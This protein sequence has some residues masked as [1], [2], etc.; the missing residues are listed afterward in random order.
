MQYFWQTM[1]EKDMDFIF[2]NMNHVSLLTRH[3]SIHHNILE[4]IP[5]IPIYYRS[6]PSFIH[7]LDISDNQDVLNEFTKL[8][9]ILLDDVMSCYVLTLIYSKPDS[10]SHIH[11]CYI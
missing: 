11:E 1:R 7:Y 2:S 4:A 6:E 9:T 3:S 5:N 8:L 10:D